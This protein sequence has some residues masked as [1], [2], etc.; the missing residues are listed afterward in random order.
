MK[1]KKSVALIL[2]IALFLVSIT[3][4]SAEFIDPKKD[5][6]YSMTLA[7]SGSVGANDFQM[8]ADKESGKIADGNKCVLNREVTSTLKSCLLN[9]CGRAVHPESTCVVFF[10]NDACRT[11]KGGSFSNSN[12]CDYLCMKLGTSSVDPCAGSCEISSYKTINGKCN[13]CK[14][15]TINCP[16]WEETAGFWCGIFPPAKIDCYRCNGY[17]SETESFALE[18]CPSNYPYGSRP[19][20]GSSPISKTC[21]RCN[22]YVSESKIVFDVACP[23]DYPYQTSVYCGTPPAK[24]KCYGCKDYVLV[25]VEVYTSNCPR[26]FPYAS[27][28]D[29]GSAPV[30]PPYVHDVELESYSYN[31]A[32]NTVLGTICIKSSD[33]STTSLVEQQVRPRT[34]LSF[35]AGSQKACDSDNPQNV[36]KVISGSGCITLTSDVYPGDYEVW[37]ILANQCYATSPSD[38]YEYENLKVISDITIS[39]DTDDLDPP[40]YWLGPGDDG[41][42]YPD[43]G[44]LTSTID[45]K[46]LLLI[47]GL[48]LIFS[49]LYK[50]ILGVFGL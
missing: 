17:I 40:D 1:Y 35:F 42:G 7:F 10:E 19:D 46:I 43:D 49:G 16:G 13:V 6:W 30:P 25:D 9:S 18:S 27:P 33:Q 3:L 4:V 15:T 50:K 39:G 20:C 37:V 8:C 21:Y 41:N 29:C 14:Q 44:S 11:T 47:V 2:T 38:F 48:F 23:G 26:E 28:V 24:I 12:V 22:G 45:L 36:H 31:T 5:L 34:V 32:D